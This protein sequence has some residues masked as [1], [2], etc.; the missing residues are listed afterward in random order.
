M[1]SKQSD[2]LTQVQ[3]LKN[4]CLAAMLKAGLKCEDAELTA[5][6]L[7]TTDTWGVFTHGSRQLRGL[8]KNVRTGRLDP[9]ASIEVVDEG[10][11]WAMVDGH[12]VIP[13]ATSCRAM[14]LAIKKAKACGLGYVGV[15]HSSHFGAAGYYAVM[16][17]QQGLIGLSMSNV[18]PVMFVTGSKGRVIGNN[19]IAYAVP[20]GKNKPVFLDIAL[21]TLAGTK[22]FVAQSEGKPIPDNWMVDDEGMPT[23]DPTGFP[24]R[25]A[26]IPMAGHKGYGLAVLVEVL[27]AVLTGSAITRQIKSWVLDLP[28]PTNEGHA[29]LAIN[30]PAMMLL[31]SFGERMDGLIQEIQEAPK[32]RGSDRIYLP[33][34]M[35]WERRE[36]ALT[37]GMVMPSY[38]LENL[39]GLAQDL[40]LDP[41]VYHLRF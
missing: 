3:D 18:D 26:Q 31:E 16:A 21:S 25:G 27:T 8:L 28:E 19:P 17:A 1:D 33:G 24:T 34:E 12:Y 15:K 2:N 11:A 6:V 38:V 9:N 29:F 5:E 30:I 23:N 35:E 39:R 7:V 32:A 13:P 22:I 4:F 14:D 40:N 20:A 10:P 36:V 41:A 37:R